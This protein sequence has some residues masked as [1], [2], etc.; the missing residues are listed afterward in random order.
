[1]AKEAT[2]ADLLRTLVVVP[3]YNERENIRSEERL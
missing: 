3:T 2:A 1:M